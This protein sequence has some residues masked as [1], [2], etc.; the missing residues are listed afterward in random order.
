[1]LHGGVS[2]ADMV[3]G[4]RKYVREGERRSGSG[5]LQRYRNAASRERDCGKLTAGQLMVRYGIVN[6]DRKREGRRERARDSNQ[7]TDVLGI[8]AAP[9]LRSQ[10]ILPNRLCKWYMASKRSDNRRVQVMKLAKNRE[11]AYQN[12]GYSGCVRVEG[13]GGGWCIE[14]D[15]ASALFGHLAAGDGSNEL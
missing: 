3:S 13:V 9:T 5:L 11:K 6:R 15:R 10:K 4:E 1:M 7:S 2:R 14:R 8:P 12:G